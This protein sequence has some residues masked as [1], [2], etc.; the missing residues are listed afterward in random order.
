MQT[1]FPEIYFQLIVSIIL[2]FCIIGFII[3]TIKLY[4][5]KKQKQLQEIETIKLS[6][7]KALLQ[8]QVEIQEEVLKNISM[9]LHDNIGQIILL[10]NINA[11]I[12]QKMQLPPEATKLIIDTKSILKNASEDISELSRSLNSERIIELGVFSAIIKEL[13]QLEKKELFKS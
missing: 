13:K 9:E 11:T 5:K 12:L 8:T 3:I 6:Y 4:N 10:A 1:Q 7:E 2:A